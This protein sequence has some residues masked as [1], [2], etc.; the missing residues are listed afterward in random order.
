MTIFCRV[1]EALKQVRA[2]EAGQKVNFT[3]RFEPYQLYP[4]FPDTVDKN[5]WYLANKHMGNADAQLVFQAHMTDTLAPMG[6][7]LKFGGAMGNTLPA[8]RVIQHFQDPDNGGTEARTTAL[9]E[10][11]YTR[12]FTR[13]QHPAA[14]DTL[15]GACVDAGVDEA[16][17]KAFVGDKEKELREVRNKVRA[18]GQDVDAVPV[19]MIE[20]KRRDITIT[21]AKEVADYVKALET[22][23][24]ESS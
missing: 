9:V 5:E 11:L 2:S 6:I 15:V 7:A 22:V 21:G 14:D 23:I 4:D 3:L 13:E 20:G 17:A 10:A 12:Y 1:D 24:K 18:N 19:V 8:H 16:E